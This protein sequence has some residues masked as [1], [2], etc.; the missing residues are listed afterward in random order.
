M[1]RIG[2]WIRIG[3][4]VVCAAV[5][6]VST[7]MLIRILIGYGHAGDV[8]ESINEGFVEI[9]LVDT[10]TKEESSAES[11]SILESES[12]T[13]DVV[14]ALPIEVIFYEESSMQMMQQYQ[15]VMDLMAQ[16]PDVVGYISIP[17]LSI[18]YPVVQADDND[19]YLNHL[20]TGEESSSGAIFLDSRCN[21]NVISAKNTVIY[22]HNM[23]DGSMF[24]NLEKLF[25]K[26]TFLNAKVEYITKEG[27][28]IF[29]PLSVY[30]ADATYPFARFSFAD[31]ADYLS[32]CRSA[33]EKSR[34]TESEAVQYGWDS[35]LI[36]LVTCTNAIS[37]HTG[38]YVFQGVLE[39]VY[40][41]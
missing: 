24:H 20:I 22:G 9:P 15:Y 29:K 39:A 34:F 10:E 37:S 3:L 28:F 16:Y 23:N 31:R 19:Y 4:L 1:K 27:I 21:K 7:I 33:V 11:E 26:D 35:C 41:G 17:S 38:R 30:R 25:E 2:M 36:T 18:N 32:F 40:P 5:C 12:E 14:D 13:E 6:V 8:Y